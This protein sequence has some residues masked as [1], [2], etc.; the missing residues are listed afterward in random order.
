[1]LLDFLFKPS[2]PHEKITPNMGAGYCPDC[3]E[4][5]EN[6]W[7]MTRCSC[8]GVKQKTVVKNGKIV[9]I[10]KYCK[11]CG[12]SS[13][14]VEELNG[15]DIVN[16]NYATVL[17]QTIKTRKENFIQTWVENNYSPMKLLPSYQF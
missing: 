15:I 16:I 14:A 4:Y 11:N 12:S 6:H 10:V 13:F 2:C 7:Y 17:K 8:C 3:G 9:A 5:V 1:M